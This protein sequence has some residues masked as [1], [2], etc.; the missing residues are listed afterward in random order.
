M[1]FCDQR[2]KGGNASL[3][4]SLGHNLL[5]SRPGMQAIPAL[6]LSFDLRN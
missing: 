5:V 3:L 1:H 4:K 2:Q 6:G